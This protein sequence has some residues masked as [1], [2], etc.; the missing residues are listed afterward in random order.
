MTNAKNSGSARRSGR[1]PRSGDRNTPCGG[2]SMCGSVPVQWLRRA[3]LL[4]LLGAAMLFPGR[5]LAAPVLNSV[6]PGACMAEPSIQLF[7]LN[8]S[9]LTGPT[10]HRFSFH[11][12]VQLQV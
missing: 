3:V 1:P 8:G 10:T 11:Q 9:G 2:M 12:D 4:P 5:A 6:T 7:T